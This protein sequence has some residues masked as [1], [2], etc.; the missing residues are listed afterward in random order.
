MNLHGVIVDI[1]FIY[2]R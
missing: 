2:I 1:F